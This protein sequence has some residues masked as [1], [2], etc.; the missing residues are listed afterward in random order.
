MNLVCLVVDV[1]EASGHNSTDLRSSG[2]TPDILDT[3]YEDDYATMKFKSEP[4]SERPRAQTASLYVG[5]SQTP[6]LDQ[7]HKNEM[8]HRSMTALQEYRD[9]LDQ[10]QQQG[11]SVR[12]TA[13]SFL[14][15]SVSTT[16][17]DNI[18]FIIYYYDFILILIEAIKNS[19]SWKLCSHFLIE[20]VVHN[21]KLTR[22][23]SAILV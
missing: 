10:Q 1:N 21:S 20:K 16:V 3:Q 8:L 23:K 4:I 14:A 22:Q 13:E 5:S 6:M 17:E 15:Q 18:D 7:L 11:Q 2:A 12:H 9:N 19:C